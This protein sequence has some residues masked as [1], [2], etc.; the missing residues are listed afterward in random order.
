[1]QINFEAIWATSLSAG[2]KSYAC[3]IC[4]LLQAELTYA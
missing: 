1:M 4:W 3:S 2:E